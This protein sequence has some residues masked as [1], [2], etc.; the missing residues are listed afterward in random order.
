MGIV[1]R[2]NDEN[3]QPRQAAN[4]H[5]AAKALLPHII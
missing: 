2:R 3:S 5:A 1:F 4:A